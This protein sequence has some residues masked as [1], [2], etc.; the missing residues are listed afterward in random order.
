MKQH[1]LCHLCCLSIYNMIFSFKSKVSI[2]NNCLL[3]YLVRFLLTYSYFALYVHVTWAFHYNTM[4]SI[5]RD[6]TKVKENGIM[7][8]RTPHPHIWMIKQ[9][10]GKEYTLWKPGRSHIQ[11]IQQHQ[12]PVA[13]KRGTF[14]NINLHFSLCPHPL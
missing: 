8:T 1:K 6:W 5:N 11:L 12:L 7:T 2:H 13:T 14:F 3:R 4:K 9:D 10:K